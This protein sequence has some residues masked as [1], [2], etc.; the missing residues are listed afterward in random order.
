[1]KVYDVIYRPFEN[2]LKI[3]MEFIEDDLSMFL[4]KNEASLNIFTA[5]SI[6]YQILNGLK[7]LHS[8]RIIHR[9]IKPSNILIDKDGVIKIADFGLS[10]N[11]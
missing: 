6:I 5:K 11:V 10:R 7:L 2:K 3:I 8:K 4:K 9:D 1:V